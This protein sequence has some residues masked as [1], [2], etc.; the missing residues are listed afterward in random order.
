MAFIMASNRKEFINILQER[1]RELVE[2]AEQDILQR[3]TEQFFGIVPLEEL[4]ARHDTDLLGCTLSYWRF[5]SRY[6]GAMEKLR[7]FN[8]DIQ[9]H[10]WQSTHSIIEI[11]HRDSPFLVDSVRMELSRAGYAIHTLQNSVMAVDRDENGQLTA[12]YA[13]DKVPAKALHES[14]MYIEVDRCSNARELKQLSS[15]LTTVLAH[16]RATV[17]DFPGMQEQARNLIK[18]LGAKT[19]TLPDCRTRCLSILRRRYSC[20]LP[21]H[22]TSARCT[23]PLTRITCPSAKWMPRARC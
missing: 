7:V 8:P 20:R 23:G 10:G 14:V 19:R 2:P 3:F 4:L 9:Q 15:R 5:F 21:R 11:V 22:R 13:R 6:D 1:L 12:L 17:S 18:A 16:V